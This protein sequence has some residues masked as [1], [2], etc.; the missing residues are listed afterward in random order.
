MKIFPEKVSL[1]KKEKNF[2]INRTLGDII[3]LKTKDKILEAH[4]NLENS[5]SI[6]QGIEKLLI[7]YCKLNN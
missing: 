2:H 1:A 5:M 4:P 7:S 3:P 6:C